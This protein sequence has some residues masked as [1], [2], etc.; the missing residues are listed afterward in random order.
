MADTLT[1]LGVKSVLLLPII[2]GHQLVGSVGVDSNREHRRYTDK[3]IVFCE[4][5]VRQAAFSIE[6]RRLFQ[7]VSDRVN[8]LTALT[9]IGRRLASTLDLDE[10][11]NSIVDEVLMATEATHASIALY[12]EP[13]NALEVK[14]MRGGETLY[15][16]DFGRDAGKWRHVRGTWSVAADS[17]SQGSNI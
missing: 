4:T 13:E 15:T 7:D 2:V 11:L 5:L 16:A 3:E 6:N 17:L 1:T 12:N 14:V 9:R 10:I 8:E